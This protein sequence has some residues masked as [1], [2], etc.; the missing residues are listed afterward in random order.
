MQIK[1]INPVVSKI[2]RGEKPT[3]S[4]GTLFYVAPDFLGEKKYAMEVD[5]WSIGILAYLLSLWLASF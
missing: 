3:E 4:Y 1:L 2:I 5:S